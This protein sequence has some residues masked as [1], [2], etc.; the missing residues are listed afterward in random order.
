MNL[1]DAFNQSGLFAKLSMLV[2]FV[3]LVVAIIYVVRPV[4]R[5]LGFMRPVS[6]ASI[7]AGICGLTAGFIAILMGIVVTKPGE[8]GM[9]SVY[10]GLA[11]ALVSPFV[12]FGLLSASW[13]LV[14]IGMWRRPAP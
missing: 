4:E 13:L 12:N 7:F 11:E 1:I 9:H 6:L 5:T 3:P 10:V 8:A 2:A 14:A